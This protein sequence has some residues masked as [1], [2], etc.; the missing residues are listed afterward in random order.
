MKLS[1]KSIM[2]NLQ[3]LSVQTL[4][5]LQDAICIR[6]ASG[7]L[8][9]DWQDVLNAIDAEFDRRLGFL[10]PFWALSA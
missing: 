7:K 2:Q 4:E 8:G 6:I 10:P 1:R 3:N 9:S 5:T